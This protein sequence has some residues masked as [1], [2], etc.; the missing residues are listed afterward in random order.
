MVEKPEE[1]RQLGRP[2]C[3]WEDNIKRILEKYVGRM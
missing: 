1:N 2:R 3:R